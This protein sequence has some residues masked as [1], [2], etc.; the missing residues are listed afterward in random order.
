[1]SNLAE[2]IKNTVIMRLL[3]IA[4]TSHIHSLYVK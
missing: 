4:K 1:M 3:R 2:M